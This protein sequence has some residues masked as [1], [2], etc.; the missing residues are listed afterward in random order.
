MAIFGD[1]E[2]ED[3]WHPDDAFEEQVGNLRSRI[4]LLDQ[5]L[6]VRSAVWQGRDRPDMLTEL[7]RRL[8]AHYNRRNEHTV[9]NRLRI[10]QLTDDLRYLEGRV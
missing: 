9:R 6:S 1:S 10:N 5:A 3:A 8:I 7:K 4:V 2:P